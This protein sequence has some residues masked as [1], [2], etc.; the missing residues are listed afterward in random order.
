[1]QN[2]MLINFTVGNF[3]SFKEKRTLSME[4]TAIKELHETV[5]TK[6]KYRLLPSAVIYGANSSGKS[7]LME[8]IAT[9]KRIILGSV[10][11]NPGDE[12]DYKP[13]A[14]VDK[15]EKTTY[16]EM[17]FLIDDTAFRYGFEYNATEIKSEW[18]YEKKDGQRE[19][20]LFLRI[21][22]D[23]NISNTLFKEGKD[24]ESKT[25]NNRLFLSLTAQL[26]GEISGK[27]M[28]WFKQCNYVSGLSSN[29]YGELTI[30][31]LLE[32]RNGY[33][34]ALK[35]FQQL[36]LGFTDLN[37]SETEFKDEMLPT[38]LSQEVKEKLKQQ[39]SKGKILS[40]KTLH[41][42]YNESG[43]IIGTNYF[44]ENEMESAGS[45]KI[46]EMSGPIFDTLMNGKLLL[47]DE[48]D[49][50][51]HPLLTLNIIRLFN[52][53]KTNPNNAQLIFATH[54]T[55]LL[56]VKNFRRD[57]IWFTEKD[58]TESTD[59]YSLVEFKSPDGTK[60]RNDRSLEK[61]YINGR[62]GAIPYIKN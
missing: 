3:R 10:K 6:K 28:N 49:A 13:F 8:A 17:E 42:I 40:V 50:K 56:S 2:L 27:I 20:N 18:L 53:H 54:D 37:I 61:D 25:T 45:K 9:M 12:L 60:I 4:A 51:L 59:L 55:N 57:Q 35:F 43:E 39:L 48:L 36:D 14:L 11:T 1:M 15:K 30:Q 52:T 41:N 38:T 5:I 31:M 62:Y 22:N 32:H 46:I 58:K 24:L 47:I 19:Y 23:F 16:F 7:N 44:N 21:D 33:E 26:N 34:D 29:G